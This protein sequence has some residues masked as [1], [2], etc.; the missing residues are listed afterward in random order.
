MGVVDLEACSEGALAEG[1]GVVAEEGV[2]VAQQCVV[3]SGV[4]VSH[5]QLLVLRDHLW[6]ERERHILLSTSHVV[7]SSGKVFCL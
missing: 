5:Q 1:V 4:T 2:V 3:D 6:T 7:K